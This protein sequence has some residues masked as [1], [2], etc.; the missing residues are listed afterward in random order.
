MLSGNQILEGVTC[1]IRRL[2]A[3][4]SSNAGI[5]MSVFTWVDGTWMQPMLN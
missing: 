3:C 5:A 2:S 4:P 1:G